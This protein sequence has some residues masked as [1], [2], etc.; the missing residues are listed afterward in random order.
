MSTPWVSVQT[1][2]LLPWKRRQVTLVLGHGLIPQLWLFLT[3][4]HVH[5]FLPSGS[6]LFSSAPCVSG[7]R[8][9]GKG[10]SPA[11]GSAALQGVKPNDFST[12]A[13]GV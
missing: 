1:L 12:V 4:T 9:P 8:A 2:P 11:G 10:L 3:H 7:V 6:F 13:L 5:T